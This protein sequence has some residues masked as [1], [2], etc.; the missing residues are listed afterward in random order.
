MC[1]TRDSIVTLV[2]QIKI[3][4]MHLAEALHFL[5]NNAN[6]IHRNI[7]PGSIFI[8]RKVH[9]LLERQRSFESFLTCRN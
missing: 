5:H 2:G 1:V 9:D 6:L 7:T 8:T 3:G 4:V